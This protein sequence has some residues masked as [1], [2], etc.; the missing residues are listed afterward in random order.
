M[1]S[2]SIDSGGAINA[3]PFPGSEQ[4]LSLV[5]LIGSVQVTASLAT[6]YIR[7]TT[8]ATASASATP[9]AS[10]TTIRIGVSATTKVGATGSA[11]GKTLLRVSAAT[12]PKATPSATPKLRFGPTAATIAGPTSATTALRKVFTRATA[13]PGI[14][15]ALLHA[16]LKYR[17]STHTTATATTHVAEKRKYGFVCVATPKATAA[18]T[19][20]LGRK[21]SASTTARAQS[22]SLTHRR[23]L[24]SAPATPKATPS[25]VP[26]TLRH[27]LV[28]S[29]KPK[30]GTYVTTFF[31][32][33]RQPVAASGVCVASTS[34][35]SLVSI[36]F[37]ALGNPRAITA[38]SP[39]LIHKLGASATPASSYSV[40]ALLHHLRNVS[41]SGAAHAS[42]AN[43]IILKIGAAPLRVTS[44]SVG[45]A[46]VLTKF[47]VIGSGH[48][49]ASGWATASL[50]RRVGAYTIAR[51]TATLAAI[52]FAATVR[53]P[54]ERRMYVTASERRMEVTV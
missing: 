17:L 47:P 11:T 4:G 37:G 46:S 14:S 54:D 39:V 52:D 34:A 16:A 51:V 28:A 7:K 50:H 45:T 8:G 23:I 10:T 13:L 49:A 35:K 53:A 3:V 25:V 38:A 48:A 44:K 19:V 22:F 21:V 20:R 6:I 41:A 30:A 36:H 12:A 40:G 32:V 24:L 9:H 29:A 31:V 33:R 27:T 15:P 5:E 43:S 2:R 18:V 1:I 26:I 42:A